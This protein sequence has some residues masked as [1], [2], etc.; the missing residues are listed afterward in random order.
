MLFRGSPRKLN[1]RTRSANLRRLAGEFAAGGRIALRDLRILLRDLIEFAQRRIDFSQCDG[2]LA[3]GFRNVAK[4]VG[5]IGHL[6]E[7]RM[8]ANARLR[9]ELHAARHFLR[10]VGDHALDLFRGFRRA[11]RERAHFLRDHREAASRIAGARRLDA[12]V[13]RE[14]VRLEG[15]LVDHDDH[16]ADFR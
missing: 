3:G 4:P 2:L 9:H 11:L 14:Q 13:Q 10:R 8:Q 7:N 5:D 1:W 12:G 6:I 15:D 16:L